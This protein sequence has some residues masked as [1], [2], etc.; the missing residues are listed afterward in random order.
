MLSA[1]VNITYLNLEVFIADLFNI[2]NVENL[3]NHN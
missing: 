3:L 2:T 1:F